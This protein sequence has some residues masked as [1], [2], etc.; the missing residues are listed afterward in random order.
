MTFPFRILD[1]PPTAEL[2]PLKDG[3]LVQ[4]DEVNYTGAK[5]LKFDCLF[6]KWEGFARPQS[7]ADIYRNPVIIMYRNSTVNREEIL[8]KSPSDILGSGA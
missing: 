4:T 1:A 7:W 2:E 6:L 5:M 8:G 3:Q